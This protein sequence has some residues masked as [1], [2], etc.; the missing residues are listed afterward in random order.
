MPPMGV[1]ALAITARF[2]DPDDNVLGLYK[3]PG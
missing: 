1:D 2:A 3:Q